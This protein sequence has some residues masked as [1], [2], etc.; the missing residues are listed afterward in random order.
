MSDGWCPFAQRV[1]GVQSYSAGGEAKVGIC[2]HA[3][4]GFLSTMADADFWNNAG[5]STHFA[6]GRR[7]QIIQMV[8]IFDRA[9]GQGRLGPRITWP[10]YG[11]MNRRNPN[12]YLI[13][14]EH[15]DWEIV[16]GI[17][18]AV[19][20][21]QWTQAEFDADLKLKR[22]LVG[23]IPSIMTFGID[24]LAGHFMFDDVNRVNCPGRYWQNEYRQLLFNALQGQDGDD[25]MKAFNAPAAWFENKLVYGST[26]GSYYIAQAQADFGLPDEAR[27]IL[28]GVKM[29][30]GVSTWYNGQSTYFAAGVNPYKVFWVRMADPRPGE[31]VGKT[32]NY[33]AEGDCQFERVECLAYN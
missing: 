31:D 17:A 5:V 2:D 29:A 32:I 8:N 13:S 26:P 1:W 25:G 16:N 21:S 20:G 33:R 28:L 18:R 11:I 27:D 23:E 22:W 19:P 30:A 4:G 10:P 24:S 12:E 9:Y 15:E 6:I 7:G 14:S 3:A